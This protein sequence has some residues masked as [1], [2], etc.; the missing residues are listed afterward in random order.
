MAIT[1]QTPYGA[2]NTTGTNPTGLFPAY[3]TGVVAGDV[4]GAF[5]T[6]EL[7]ATLAG[8][9]DRFRIEAKT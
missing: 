2:L 8:P 6:Y 3:P 5:V 4:T 1:Y 7:P 9:S